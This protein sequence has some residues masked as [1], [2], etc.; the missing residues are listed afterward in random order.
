MDEQEAQAIQ[1]KIDAF[2]TLVQLH[3]QNLHC[4]ERFSHPA[5]AQMDF[6]EIL[7]DTSSLG[8]TNPRD[9]IYG[10]LG[11]ANFPAKPMTIKNWITAR[12]HHVF[13]LIDYSADMTSLL[14]AV[15]WMLLIKGGLAVLGNFKAFHSKTETCQPTLPSWV[16]D[17][18]LSG[19]LFRKGILL[20]V[21]YYKVGTAWSENSGTKRVYHHQSCKDN[22]RLLPLNQIVIRGVVDPR[23]YEKEKG[24]WSMGK[25]NTMNDKAIWN[26]KVDVFST[27]L[28]VQLHEYQSHP[29][30]TLR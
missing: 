14:C 22:S 13:I 7:L 2:S 12:Q 24:V 3:R 27:D 29:L 6:I 25:R 17:W 23:F 30:S 5:V 4:F 8:A 19:A 9:H 1:V 16:I 18:R 21:G 26:S 10:I 28:I 15:T 20:P 11:I